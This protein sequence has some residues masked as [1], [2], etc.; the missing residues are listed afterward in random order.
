MASVYVIGQV[1]GGSGFP[2]G[3]R[4]LS[5]KWQLTT[6]SSWTKIAGLES[7]ETQVDFPSGGQPAVF[8]HPLDIHYS[9]SQI[10]GWPKF[11][12]TV[13]Q[14]DA[15]GRNDVVGYGFCHI[16]TSAGQ[17]EVE[18][19]TWRPVSTVG[20]EVQ[21]FFVGGNPQLKDDSLVTSSIDRFKLRT[22][23][24][25]TVSLTVSVLLKGFSKH[26]LIFE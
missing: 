8:S 6:G 5:C 17:H 21:A 19:M 3:N 23:T 9:A 1:T 15:F 14:Q 12:C 18:C 20:D 11:Q 16:P 2:S 22:K 13:Y 7:G 25:G 4:G 24:M 10:Q 26:G